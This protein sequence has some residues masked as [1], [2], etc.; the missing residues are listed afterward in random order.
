MGFFSWKCPVCDV[1]VR[2]I[3][4]TQDRKQ[5]ECVILKPDGTYASGDY[6]GYGNIIMPNGR[7]FNIMFLLDYK[8]DREHE[9]KFYHRKCWLSNGCPDFK[10]AKWSE[11][12]DDQGFFF[13]ENLNPISK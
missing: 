2:S 8:K 12:A 3:W 5:I 7:M 9:V 1:S 6:D 4:A 13:D 10:N 11:Y